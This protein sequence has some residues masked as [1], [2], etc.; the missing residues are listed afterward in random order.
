MHARHVSF[1]IWSSAITLFTTAPTKLILNI[2]TEAAAN[3]VHWT[4]LQNLVRKPETHAHLEKH[5]DVVL[6]LAFSKKRSLKNAI[7][8]PTH[9]HTH[10]HGETYLNMDV[11]IS[12]VRE[13]TPIQI[14][15]I[16]TVFRNWLNWWYVNAARM[17]N[18]NTKLYSAVVYIYILVHTQSNTPILEETRFFSVSSWR[19]KN[20]TVP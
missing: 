3:T 14:Q 13:R 2:A 17:K 18:V 20:T 10:T 12:Q 4:D 15:G 19:S 11:T 6:K 5:M 16:V 1:T 9:T 7:Q 8:N